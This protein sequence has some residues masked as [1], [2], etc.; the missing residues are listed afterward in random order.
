MYESFRKF[1]ARIKY[2]S[3]VEFLYANLHNLNY[4]NPMYHHLLFHPCVEH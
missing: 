2:R 3:M 4:I 1:D